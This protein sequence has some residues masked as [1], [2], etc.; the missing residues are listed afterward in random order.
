[1]YRQYF[2]FACVKLQIKTVELALTRR[3]EKPLPLVLSVQVR[4]STISQNN[5]ACF[6]MDLYRSLFPCR[7]CN[8]GACWQMQWITFKFHSPFP[9][10]TRISNPKRPPDHATSLMGAFLLRQFKES[11]A[12]RQN[13]TDTTLVLRTGLVHLKIITCSN[14]KKEKKKKKRGKKLAS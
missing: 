14:E 11:Q 5:K 4:W 7:K 8:L 10:L 13:I 12:Q 3:S 6:P 1:M 9:S 2:N